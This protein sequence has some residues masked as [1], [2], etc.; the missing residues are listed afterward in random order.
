M[1]VLAIYPEPDF[2]SPINLPIHVNIR[3]GKYIFSC[4]VDFGSLR[5][6]IGPLGYIIEKE[7]DIQFSVPR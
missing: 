1:G 2:N 3:I 6:F 4:E 5:S 7:L